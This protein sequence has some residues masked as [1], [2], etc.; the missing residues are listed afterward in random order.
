MRARRSKANTPMPRR[1]D[2]APSQSHP[3]NELNDLTGKE[4]IKFTKSW[5]VC[6]SP[7][8]HRNRDVELHPARFPEEM[9]SEFL[10]FFTKQEQWV[11]DPFVG[12][13]ATLV[14]C[15]ENNR[16]GV[17]IEI[18]RKYAEKAR[19]RLRDGRCDVLCA[20]ARRVAEPELWQTSAL[21]G[22][23]RG[24]DGLPQFDF[25][26]TSPP[27]WRMLRTSRGGVLS[28][29]KMRA[30]AGLDTYY[31]D[32]P[33]DLGNIEDYNEFIEQLGRIFDACARVLR[34]GKYLVVVM[35]NL[36]A[37]TGEILPLAWDMARRI[38][39]TFLLQGERIWCQNSKKLGIWGY[40]KI[41]VPN[42]HHHY[43]LIFRK[44]PAAESGEGRI[45]EG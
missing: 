3:R 34:E 20:D 11:L 8:Y 33:D 37:P 24:P 45:V 28:T 30:R 9:V 17:G 18:N 1:A 38:S 2:N 26:M 6:D 40:P 32:C 15:Q 23:E 12:S 42:Y 29:H 39:R 13:G 10:R 36:R 41:F 25:I 44:T 27:Y 14:A 7:R 5:F 22:L 19:A 16:W 35:Q 21:D 43:C 4:W 31:S